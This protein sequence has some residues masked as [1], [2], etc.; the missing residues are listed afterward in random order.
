MSSKDVTQRQVTSSAFTDEYINNNYGFIWVGGQAIYWNYAV[1]SDVVAESVRRLADLMSPAERTNAVTYSRAL[2]RVINQ[3]VLL[4]R[5]DGNYGDGIEPTRWVGSEDILRLWLQSG[6]Q[7]V[8]YGQCW[9]FAALLTTLL[10]ASDIPARTVTNY[11][12]HHDRGLTSDGT[13]VLRQ[14]DNIVQRDEDQWNFHVWSE[15]WLERPDLVQP[16]DWNAVDATPQEPSPLAPGQP[17]RSGPAYVPFI[18]SN[19]QLANYDTLFILAEVNARGVCPITGQPLQIGTFVV[20]KKPGMEPSLYVFNNPEIITGNYKIPT[21]KRD[22]ESAS[23]SFPPTYTGCEREGG[24]RI[25]SVPP[26]PRVG[27][28]FVITVTE[29]NVSVEDIVI[30]MELRS[31]MGESLGFIRNFTGTRRVDVT[32]S[33]Y[34]PYVDESSVFRFSV[35]VYNESGAFILH[36]AL[37]ITLEY[38]MVQVD[39]MNVANTI[40]M[41]LTYT[42]PLSVPMTG[43]VVNVAGPDYS[44]ASMAQPDIPAN[45]RFTSTVTVQCGNNTDSNVMIPVSLDSNETLSAYGSGWSSCSER[46]S[47]GGIVMLSEISLLQVMLLSLLTLCM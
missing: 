4:G 2:T 17:Y 24:M 20:T 5:W 25:N 19:V 13:S 44:Y 3:H 41:T 27:E 10:R 12:S 11:E 36:D 38:D 8:R 47:N 18:R 33:D 1:G 37:R 6:G 30:R 43:V 29:G 9:V 21:T 42:N 23:P 31:Y 39:A 7:K 35:G 15:A 22:S 14:F 16:A 40:A 26:N 34:R 45:G 46:S 32:E 28:D